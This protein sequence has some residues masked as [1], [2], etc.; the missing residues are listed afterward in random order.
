MEENGTTCHFV[1]SHLVYRHL[2]HSHFIFGACVCVWSNSEC[3][4]SYDRMCGVCYGKQSLSQWQDVHRKV[5]IDRISVYEISAEMSV[6]KI[7]L[8]R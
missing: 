6:D 7:V 8:T 4:N 5:S 3:V 2:V 1:C